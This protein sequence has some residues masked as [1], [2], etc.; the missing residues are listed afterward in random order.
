M[1]LADAQL[2]SIRK[3]LAPSLS[4]T[5]HAGPP[6]AKTHPSPSLLSKL[7]LQVLSLYNSALTLVRSSSSSA[8]SSSSSVQTDDPLPALVKYL[9]DGRDFAEAMSRKWLGVD[10][11]ESSGGERTGEA[12][13]WLRDAKK[14]LV[15]SSSSST[16]T[17]PKSS[18]GSGGGLF[19]KLGGGGGKEEKKERKGRLGDALESVDAF[20]QA[21]EKANN[22]VR[23]HLSSLPRDQ[24]LTSAAPDAV[25]VVLFALA[26]SFLSAP[27]DSG[28]SSGPRV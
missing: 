21:Y 12:I 8:G 2:L 6:L 16:G 22:Q 28:R 13:V 4:S 14:T 18:N 15:E 27:P 3:L 17:V 10:A 20:L 11:G 24:A 26:T 25:I 23:P 9:K 5:P 1:L 7:Y 19:K